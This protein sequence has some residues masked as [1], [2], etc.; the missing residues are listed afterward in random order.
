MS[1]A[2][3]VLLEHARANRER[4]R[5]TRWFAQ[6][7]TTPE[8]AQDLLRYAEESE[9]TADELEARARA[10]AET[11]AR[12]HTLNAEVR[13]LIEQARERINQMPQR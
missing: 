2:L 1:Q 9:R 10:L 12:T 13:D 8:I 3:V 5:R 6:G 11:I 7:L 4:A